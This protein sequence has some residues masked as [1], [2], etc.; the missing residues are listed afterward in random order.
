MDPATF[1]D[2]IT[3]ELADAPE[4]A[5]RGY[6]ARVFTVDPVAGLV[7]DGVEPLNHARRRR[8]DALAL[9]LEADGSAPSTR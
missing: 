6:L 8:P 4:L 2:L 7:D 1:V 9:T 5:Q 3:T